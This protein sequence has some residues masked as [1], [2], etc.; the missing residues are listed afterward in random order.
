MISEK[1]GGL[2]EAGNLA[3]ACFYCNRYKGPNIAGFAIPGGTVTR[4]F[5]PRLDAWNN[6]FEWEGSIVVPR[7]EIGAAT[8]AVLR[9]NHPDAQA[10]RDVLMSGDLWDSDKESQ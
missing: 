3:F 5:H 8:V 6:H 4:L 2:T 7:T 10:I 9:I 1:H